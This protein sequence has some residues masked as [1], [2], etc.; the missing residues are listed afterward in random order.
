ML[1]SPARSTAGLSIRAAEHLVDGQIPT[2]R[3]RLDGIS[4]VPITGEPQSAALA[5]PEI[6]TEIH[7]FA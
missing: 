5:V 1:D 4:I 2:C 6:E 7:P 3:I